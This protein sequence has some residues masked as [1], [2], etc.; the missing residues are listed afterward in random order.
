MFSPS[1]IAQFN[2][3]CSTF[4][5]D[6]SEEMMEKF[7][8]YASLLLEWNRRIH[9]VSKRDATGSRI[10]RH[11]VDSLTIFRAI[12]MPSH[13]NVL[14]LGAGAGFPSIPMK[15]VRQDL[16]LTLIESVHKKCLFLKKLNE[17]LNQGDVVV[18][19]QRAEELASRTDFQG[20]FDLVTAKALGRLVDIAEIS[21]PFLKTGGILVTYKGRAAKEEARST[22][23]PSELRLRDVIR[24]N[25]PELDLVRWLVVTEK[26]L[27]D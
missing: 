24:V 7:K 6:L 2:T 26:V 11:F 23:L 14:D 9:L 12:G 16:Q 20:R 27:P 5:L 15:I 21:V 13:S 22:A 8:T 1:E 3:I 17:T 4:G 25:V 19:D 18:V 10:M